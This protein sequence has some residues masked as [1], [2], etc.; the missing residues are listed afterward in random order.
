MAGSALTGQQ[1]SPQDSNADLAALIT[2]LSTPSPAG[3]NRRDDTLL[4]AATAAL[5]ARAEE[6]PDERRRVYDDIISTRP[7]SFPWDEVRPAGRGLAFL[8]QFAPWVDTGAVVA[9]KRL[10][11]RGDVVDVISVSGAHRRRIDPTIAM[12]SAPYVDRLI[13]LD[14]PQAWASWGNI[15]VFCAQALEAAERLTGAPRT[16][17]YSRAMWAPSHF[18]AALYTLRHP[19]VPWVA[20]FSDPLSM[21]V[22]GEPR[23]GGPVTREEWIEPVFHAVEQRFGPIPEE[24]MGVFPLT[25]W[26][27]YALADE[28]V[29]TNE[30]QR[31]TMLDAIGDVAIRRSVEARSV[32]RNHPTLPASYYEVAPSHY[33]VDPTKLNLAYF[34]EFYSTRGIGDVTNAIRML[35]ADLR[36]QVSLHVFTNYVPAGS[37]RSRPAHM[38]P[39][40]YDALVKRAQDGIGADGIEDQVHLNA[41]LPYLEFLNVTGRFDHLIV[42]D[43]KRGRHF[44]VNPY[45]P[46]KW[47]DYANST[48][49]TWALVEEGSSLDAKNADVTSPVG[50]PERA[51]SVLRDLIRAKREEGTA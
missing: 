18:A 8:Y 19:D 51:A 3:R 45:L 30:L 31:V 10:R 6:G 13:H 21:D 4:R 12:V 43:A 27:A 47:S 50:D 11:E 23:V 22:E 35:P 17:V 29:F 5:R 42:C 32:V 26:I 24:R 34:G 49:K 33:T 1:P 16:H 38:T 2:R 28:V 46:S 39:A 37:G 40:A 41:A 15:R 7:T 9:S 25:E 44:A 14:I 20:E 36:Q 48:A